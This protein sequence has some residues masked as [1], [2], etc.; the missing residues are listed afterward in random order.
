MKEA[1]YVTI[2]WPTL[3]STLKRAEIISGRFSSI[4]LPNRNHSL[5]TR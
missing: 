3:A 5:V 1:Y 2:K 4:S